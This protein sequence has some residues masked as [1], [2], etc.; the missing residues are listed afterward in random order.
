MNYQHKWETI[1]AEKQKVS[2]NKAAAIEHY[3]RA[4]AGAKE[5]QFTHEEALANELAAKFYLDWGKK[6]IAESYMVEAYY[7]Y[8]R[9]GAAAKAE[10][11][12]LLY[13]QLL[14]PILKSAEDAN[15]LEQTIS[16]TNSWKNS[17]ELLDLGALL[18]ASQTISQ[19]IELDRA[20]GNLL[21]ILLANAGADCCV[22][23]LQNKE[24]LEV[25]AKAKLTEFPQ[26]LTPCSFESSVDI[27]VNL[28]NK[29][30]RSLEPIVLVNATTSN[31]FSGD[32]YVR[33]HKPLSVLCMP[34]LYRGN[35]I[36]ILYL[37]NNLSTGAFTRERFKMLQ[38]LTA[39]AA[40]SLQ[41]A[42]LYQEVQNYAVYLEQ[43]VEKRTVELQAAKEEAERAN[44]QKTNFLNFITHEL[45]TP[46]N[47][48]MGMSEALEDNP[49]D[50][51]DLQLRHVQKIYQSGD[52]LRTLINDLLDLAKIE[53]G[54]LE[55][56]CDPNIIEDLCNFSID[57]ILPQSNQKQIKLSLNIPSQLPQI[58]VDRTRIRQV[59][60]NL[61][62]NAVK[63]TPEEGEIT[64]EVKQLQY[65]NTA[66][67]RF[68][69]TD[70][71]IGISDESLSKLFQ[72]FVQIDSAVNRTFKGTGLGL[73]L[74]KKMVEL[75]GGKISVSSELGKG[76]CFA[77]ELPCSDL[78]FVF[79]L[80]QDSTPIESSAT[81]RAHPNDTP[82]LP[83]IL[84][85]DNNEAYIESTSNYL[86]AKGYQIIA[87][88][89]G[90]EAI[91]LIK[92]H[93]PAVVL[94][95]IYMPVLDGL[96]AIRQLRQ[97]PQF[98]N[99]PI[100]A[101]T[102]LSMQG[103]EERCLAAGANYYFSKP[104]R[105]SVLAGAIHN[106]LQSRVAVV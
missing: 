4:I 74:V 28:V 35:S 39:Q 34:I 23:M 52:H 7:C 94:M 27:P 46:L 25:I 60:I 85:V 61:L 86:T 12:T 21:T 38:L 10:E 20:I 88:S 16:I 50:M 77:F 72:P 97:D 36:G 18:K 55:L 93:R 31:E 45:R 73:N 104:V 83:T 56:K 105:F 81:D 2:G 32:V 71:G 58:S 11:L 51:S 89:N 53:A 99:L 96:S 63:Y 67:I 90:E 95:D 92:Q 64:L 49:G 59:L 15:D 9:W 37:E 75:H 79:P 78:P 29:V 1:E 22:L 103:D 102:A 19:E 70:T 47:S 54:K 26:L 66:A 91:E 42:Q 69:V 24:N 68:A 80:P 14:A 43:K 57:T 65:E 82:S 87:A 30:K 13:P 5:H 84:I 62:G 98:T 48:I 8:S 44:L 17:C 6:M 41:N 106:S 40:I 100:I 33:K 3:D 76:S 101:V